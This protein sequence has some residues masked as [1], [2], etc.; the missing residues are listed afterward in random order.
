MPRIDLFMF[1]LYSCHRHYLAK[2]AESHFKSWIA[3][4][5]V[6]V[7]KDIPVSIVLDDLKAPTF[8]SRNSGPVLFLPKLVRAFKSPNWQKL[9]LSFCGGSKSGRR[10]VYRRM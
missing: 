7:L 8:K 9:Q 10:N 5:C 6:V 1:A 2:L 3:G 4:V